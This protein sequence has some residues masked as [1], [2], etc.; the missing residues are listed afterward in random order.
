MEVKG[1]P[2][3]RRRARYHLIPPSARAAPTNASL[4]WPRNFATR[5]RCGEPMSAA[6]GEL[7]EA[8]RGSYT[9]AAK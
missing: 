4:P 3:S 1:R 5:F 9:Q 8:N 7:K 2:G 6:S